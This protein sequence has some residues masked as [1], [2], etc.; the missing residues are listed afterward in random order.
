M[1]RPLTSCERKKYLERYIN[2]VGRGEGV[3]GLK[4]FKEFVRREWME[5]EKEDKENREGN[6]RKKGGVW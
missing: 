1:R 5:V 3:N 6:D 2:E 4:V